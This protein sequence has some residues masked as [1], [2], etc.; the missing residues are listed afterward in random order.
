MNAQTSQQQSNAQA[1]VPMKDNLLAKTYQSFKL[2]EQGISQEEAD[3]F[4]K[5]QET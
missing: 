1:V 2:Q 3:D 5:Q 4:Q